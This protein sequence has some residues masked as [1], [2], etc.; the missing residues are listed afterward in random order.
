MTTN[1]R[2]PARRQPSGLGYT[3]TREAGHRKPF[4]HERWMTDRPVMKNC[5]HAHA[6]ALKADSENADYKRACD[7]LV[8]KGAVRPE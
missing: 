4:K 5:W 3:L 2:S 8:E 7:I 6:A 1:T